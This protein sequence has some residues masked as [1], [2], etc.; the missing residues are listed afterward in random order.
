MSFLLSPEESIDEIERLSRMFN[1]PVPNVM[2]GEDLAA[3]NRLGGR[4]PGDSESTPQ[5]DSE[6]ILPSIWLSRTDLYLRDGI[7][8][9]FFYSRKMPGRY[10]LE[11]LD[12]PLGSYAALSPS[13]KTSTAAWNSAL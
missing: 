1:T 9:P 3:L 7:C 6:A 13:E 11:N 5:F 4:P 8:F 2:F 12:L 10:G